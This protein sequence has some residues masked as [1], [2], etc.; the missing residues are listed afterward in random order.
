MPTVPSALRNLDDGRHRAELY[1]MWASGHD[2]GLAH[3]RVL[4]MM[5]PRETA[6]AERVRTWLLNGT[7][8][9]VSPGDIVRAPDA[10]FED[11]ERAL[12]ALGDESGSLDQALRLLGDFYTRKHQLMGWVKKQMAYPLV[13]GLAACFIAP[14]P[15]LV[16][17]RPAEYAIAAF[18]AAA[19]ALLAAGS[20]VT[21]VAAAFGRRPALARA[22]MARALATAVEA[23]LPLDR[24]VRL[25]GEASAHPEIR[26][27]VGRA[28]DRQLG[29]RSLGDSLAACPHLTPDFIA[30]LATAEAT[31][32]FTPLARLAELYEDGFR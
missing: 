10:P 7:R 16:F 26:A 9:G 5:S 13:T 25:A 12:L 1:R 18:S 22:R 17:G 6:P 14:L 20:L 28:T 3:P 30:V 27:F 23:G 11:F 2:A 4:E 29:T 32:D 31:G 8:R 19:L 24:A 15:L 21:A